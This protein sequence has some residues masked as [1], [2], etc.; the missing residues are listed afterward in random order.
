MDAFTRYDP[1]RSGLKIRRMSESDIEPLYSLLSDPAVM[2]YIEPPYTLK[3]AQAF[4]T[5]AGMCEPPLIYAVDDAS[6]AFIGYIIYHKYDETSMELGWVLAQSEWGKGYASSLT[7]MLIE[8]TRLIGM[9]AVI[10]C[11]PEQAATKS[12]AKKH[13]FVYCGMD[14]G[15]EVYRLHLR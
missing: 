8:N 14:G 11:V 13:G 12:I 3:A 6:G 4:L 15:C 9:D 5:S 10:E 7:Q 2:K 1:Y